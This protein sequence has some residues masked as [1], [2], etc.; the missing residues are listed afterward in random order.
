MWLHYY[1]GILKKKIK[2]NNKTDLSKN[3]EIIQSIVN[4]RRRV[5]SPPYTIKT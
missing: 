2:K 5:K 4:G 3:W 1:Y